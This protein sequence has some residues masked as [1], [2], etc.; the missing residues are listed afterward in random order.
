[1]IHYTMGKT[2]FFNG[3]EHPSIGILRKDGSFE[4]VRKFEYE[5]FKDKLS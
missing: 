4:L 3:V 1:M 5:D 2:T